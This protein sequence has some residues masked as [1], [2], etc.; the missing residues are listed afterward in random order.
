MNAVN[1]TTSPGGLM[2]LSHSA[3]PRVLDA[4][5]YSFTRAQKVARA[6]DPDPASSGYF[7]SMTRELSAL[8]WT[9]RHARTE[10]GGGGTTPQVPIAVCA[11]A[12]V[13]C[14]ADAVPDSD[15]AVA[16]IDQWIE[17]ACAMLAN[18]PPA[19]AGQLDAWWSGMDLAVSGRFMTVG[20]IMEVM[21]TPVIP[22]AQLSFQFTG[23]DW[24]SLI[25]PTTTFRLRAQP[26]LLTLDWR[27]YGRIE[28]ELV[29]ELQQELRDK[30]RSDQLDLTTM[31]MREVLS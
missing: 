27:A 23:S 6:A 25:T 12:L 1:L 31:S 3:S 19:V 14:L 13:Q 26:V 9:V 20:P 7:A 22:A 10:T 24:R 28:N 17:A 4:Y 21:S 15:T 18:P 8:G 11:E 2:A 5:F 30:I 16:T 29:A